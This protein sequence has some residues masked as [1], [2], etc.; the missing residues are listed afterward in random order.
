M[1]KTSNSFLVA[2]S[3]LP[4]E[5]SGEQQ[6]LQFRI[7]GYPDTFKAIAEKSLFI[8]EGHNPAILDEIVRHGGG[9]AEIQEYDG[10]RQKQLKIAGYYPF[11]N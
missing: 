9:L 1:Q 6:C 4:E 7:P 3:H 5:S 10:Q 2:V 8:R 11:F